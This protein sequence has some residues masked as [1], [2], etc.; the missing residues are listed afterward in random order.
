MIQFFSVFLSISGFNGELS[1]NMKNCS[2]VILE[3]GCCAMNALIGLYGH[4]EY[5]EYAS[6]FMVVM[7]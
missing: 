3:A 2:S 6:D 7:S 5:S 1:L 4:I